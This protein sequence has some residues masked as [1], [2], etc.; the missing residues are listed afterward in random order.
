MKHN[1]A[2]KSPR[3]GVGAVVFHEE[4]VLLVLRGRPPAEGQWTIPGGRLEWGETLEHATERELLEETGIV[5]KAV[6]PVFIFDSI[7]CDTSGDIQFHYVIVD[8]EAR[9]VS[10]EPKPGDDALDAR[11]INRAQLGTLP[12]HEKTLELLRTIYNFSFPQT[13][14]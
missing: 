9:Y 13:N 4:R 8:Y 6:K 10:G 11:W 14:I 1:Q 3:I 12:V 7:T 5:C 2:H